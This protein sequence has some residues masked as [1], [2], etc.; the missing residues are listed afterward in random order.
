MK[1]TLQKSLGSL[2]LSSSVVF[3]VVAGGLGL[4]S[5]PASAVSPPTLSL[6]GTSWTNTL[7][8]AQTDSAAVA[9]GDGTF[10]AL[11]NDNVN[12]VT[13]DSNTSMVST[14]GAMWSVG[15]TLPAN[16]EWSS[17]A[18]GNGVFV[19]TAYN[20]G[21]A[22]VSSNAGASWTSVDVNAFV[23]T[24]GPITYG[25]GKFV[26]VNPQSNE[27]ATST[28]GFSWVLVSTPATFYSITYA[29]ATFVATDVVGNFYSSADAMTWLTASELA[30]D[31]MPSVAGSPSG[32]FVSMPSEYSSTTNDE[33]STNDGVTW[34]T[35][36]LP[37]EG[38][39]TWTVIYADGEFIAVAAG[40][41]SYAVSTTG[42]TWNLYA[43]AGNPGEMWDALAA[44][45][46]SVVALDLN[47][48][49]DAV[50]NDGVPTASSS[51]NGY[52]ATLDTSTG[53]PVTGTV[54]I[55][56][57]AG[58]S[59]SS[60]VWLDAGS[61]GDGGEYFA[62]NCIIY[63]HEVSGD[64]VIA[65]YSGGNYS[66]VQPSQVTVVAPTTLLTLS[67][68]PT[69]GTSGNSYTVSILGML[70][71][72]PTGTVTMNDSSGGSCSSS[73]WTDIELD[74]SGEDYA[75]N[76]SIA[77]VEGAGTTIVATY[78]GGDFAATSNGLII[79]A[80]PAIASAGISGTSE[81]GYQLSATTTGV[82]GFPTPTA[83]YQWLDN[84]VAIS[85]A[86]SLI[87]DVASADLGD[88]ITVV[89]TETNGIGTA[90]S[91]T[92]SG[93]ALVTVPPYT[94]P[95]TTTTTTQ[96]PPAPTTTPK[97]AIVKIGYARMSAVLT[98]TKRTVL[99]DMEMKL[100]NGS[101]V[102]VT[103]YAKGDAKLARRRA[104]IVATYLKAH[105]GVSVTVSLRVGSLHVREV[106][107]RTTEN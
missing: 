5:L 31:Q 55:A 84:G 85:G 91:A 15:G 90:A 1:N 66:S 107:V 53:V 70:N 93:T 19:A 8:V 82:T 35:G 71:L 69:A 47:F 101:R 74:G 7:G 51:G 23:A 88:S 41:S 105:A 87:Y 6:S 92:S 52:V 94:P 103:G 95:A 75:A 30:N 27:I 76:C 79:D 39:G 48:T 81:V 12:I 26:M 86:T 100:V 77:S 24:W 54:T 34:Q 68:N 63:V 44:N 36:S 20:D 78:V 106:L 67:G 104:D 56:D 11:G 42:E 38:N 14:S 72:Y 57:G 59:C 50:L 45:A 2:A 33:Y 60:N 16:A 98:A 99:S 3:A 21:D 64:V 4:S 25:G 46:T 96:P 37:M 22:A 80:A 10:V 43:M 32:D 28:N 18:Y 65:T 97:P 62:A 73:S 61:D 89:V 29:D 17:V 13:S 9:Y 83:T 40:S 58:G 49:F 102:S